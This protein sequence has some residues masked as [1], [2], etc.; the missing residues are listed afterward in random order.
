MSRF[1][2]FFEPDGLIGRA[3]GSPGAGERRR[4]RPT[5]P[6][7]RG[8]RC[9]TSGAPGAP[10]GPTSRRRRLERSGDPTS[11]GHPA[12]PARRTSSSPH[13]G[14]T[15]PDTEHPRSGPPSA[16][17]HSRRSGSR[18]SGFCTRAP[19][20]RDSDASAPASAGPRGSGGTTR[21][22][23]LRVMNPASCQLLHP[24]TLS[25]P[26]ATPGAR[27]WRGRPD[28]LGCSTR[29]SRI[30]DEGADRTSAARPGSRRRT[31]GR[32]PSHQR[33]WFARSDRFG[34]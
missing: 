19:G 17:A 10:P 8:G 22:C 23:D 30:G 18:S 6:G 5:P 24:A 7:G 27:R 20:T 3:P 11:T 21:T 16:G 32:T 1:A 15:G 25:Q 34:Y 2:R 13:P 26:D 12:G 9:C 28:G 14:G 31:D 29:A 4:S 33:R